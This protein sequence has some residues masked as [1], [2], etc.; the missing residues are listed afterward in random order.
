MDCGSGTVNNAIR[1]RSWID[2][3][4]PA[5]NFAKDF[6]RILI[7]YYICI[8]IGGVAQLV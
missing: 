2:R 8:R 4:P 3:P 6:L 5:G 7:F 1:R